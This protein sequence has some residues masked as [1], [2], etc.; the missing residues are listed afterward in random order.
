MTLGS[1][2]QNT[3]RKIIDKFGDDATWY[4]YSSATISTDDEGYE[5]ITWGTGTSIKTIASDHIKI[6][7]VIQK[8]GEETTETVTFLIADNVSVDKKD[9]ITLNSIDYEIESVGTISV[10]GY[11]VA[12][13]ISL[14]RID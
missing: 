12:Q 8:Q 10:Q 6:Q 4:D 3:I 9:K 5:T 14:N 7:N 13:R 2:L 11:I 1:S